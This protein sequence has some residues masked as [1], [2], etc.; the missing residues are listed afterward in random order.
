LQACKITV[1]ALAKKY[2]KYY[3]GRCDNVL[4]VVF[5]SKLIYRNLLVRF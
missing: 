1:G 2:V 5:G 3:V 4:Y